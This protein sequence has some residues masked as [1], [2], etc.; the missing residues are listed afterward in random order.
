MEAAVDAGWIGRPCNG[1]SERIR[2]EANGAMAR[3]R[4]QFQGC[5]IIDAIFTDPSYWDVPFLQRGAIIGSLGV[6]I[7]IHFI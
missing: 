7:F 6:I 2:R 4:S 5:A 1:F 3:D